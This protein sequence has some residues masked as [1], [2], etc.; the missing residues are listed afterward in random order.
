[1][2]ILDDVLPLAC[3]LGAGLGGYI[4]SGT[5]A[6][7]DLS[8]LAFL[9]CVVLRW[10]N[11]LQALG[12]KRSIRHHTF[13]LESIRVSHFSEKLRWALQRSGAVY[14]EVRPARLLGVLCRPPKCI[15]G[16]MLL[17]QADPRVPV[18]T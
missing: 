16:S 3:L 6:S 1:V 4:V 13:V 15:I 7:L 11:G 9:F 12:I 18:L 5:S 10:S 14:T 2:S 8:L 17:H